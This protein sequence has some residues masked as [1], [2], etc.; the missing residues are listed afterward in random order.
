MS[1]EEE[2]AGLAD[3]GIAW[4]E[5]A[6]VEVR[7]GSSRGSMLLGWKQFVAASIVV[8][9]TTVPLRADMTPVSSSNGGYRPSFPA[10]D[11]TV[12]QPVGPFNRFNGLGVIDLS[13]VPAWPSLSSQNHAEQ[14]RQTRSLPI[15]V[16]GQN[17]ACLCLYALLGLGLCRSVPLV[18]KLSCGVIPDWYHHGGPFQIGHSHAVG[19]DCLC[20]VM[21]VCFI[22]PDCTARDFLPQYYW[23]TI[24][25]L[26]RKSLFTPNVLASRG[27]PSVS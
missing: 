3:D 7:I 12:A 20:S 17:S 19:P 16:D 25:S 4:R 26:L 8:L 9:A 6:I 2:S 15:L 11:L 14:L 24:A 5:S 21:V 1:N 27:P 10:R 13:A 22:Q 18:R 23:G